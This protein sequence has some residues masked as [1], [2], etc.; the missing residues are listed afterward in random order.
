MYF[1]GTIIKKKYELLSLQWRHNER[2]IMCKFKNPII[3]CY[4]EY[5]SMQL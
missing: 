1:W 3:V 4:S 2:E 5:V